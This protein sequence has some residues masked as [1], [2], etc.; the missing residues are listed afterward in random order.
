MARDK[1][2]GAFQNAV[3]LV[4]HHD[5]HSLQE[6]WDRVDDMLTDCV[7]RML[8]SERDRAVQFD[9]AG[10]TGQSREDALA[11]TKGYRKFVRGCFDHHYQVARY[12]AAHV[13]HAGDRPTSS[14][15]LSPLH[16]IRPR[17]RGSASRAG[18][19]AGEAP[20]A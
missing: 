6:A 17:A 3:L 1:A 7:Q 13:D 2:A 4:Q 8:A 16:L 15:S 11:C 9:A 12:T 20:R 10:I 5:H 19:G 14:S 18:P